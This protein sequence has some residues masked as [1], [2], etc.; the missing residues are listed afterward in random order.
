M[1][2]TAIDVARDRQRG[3]GPKVYQ[4]LLDATLNPRPKPWR[5]G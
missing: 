4:L 2:L 5:R 1:G 3:D